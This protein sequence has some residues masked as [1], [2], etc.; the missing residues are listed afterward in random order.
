MG[1]ELD[2]VFGFVQGFFVFEGFVLFLLEFF[3]DRVASVEVQLFVGPFEA[4]FLD[5]FEN[6][7][8][9]V[10]RADDAGLDHLEFGGQCG[11]QFTDDVLVFFASLDA[12]WVAFGYYR[13]GI[14][15]SPRY[16][17]VDFCDSL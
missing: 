7:E 3:E 12:F 9:F 17:L 4:C 11:L 16:W 8:E 2:V 14:R 1:G 6:A 15:D 5:D 13:V 10:C